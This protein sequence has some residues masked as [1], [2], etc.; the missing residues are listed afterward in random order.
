MNKI[1][2]TMQKLL[3]KNILLAVM[4]F[5]LIMLTRA[6]HELTSLNLP[7]ASLA[8][9]IAAGI[10]L[11]HRKFL[12]LFIALIVSVDAYIININNMTHIN[13]ETSYLG[14]IFTYILTWELGRKFLS[15]DKSLKA[16]L[17]FP[18][19]F[20][21]IVSSYTISFSSHYFLSGWIN[22]P[23]FYDGLSFLVNNFNSFFIPNAVYFGLLYGILKIIHKIPKLS[24]LNFTSN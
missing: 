4:L 7:D 22:N 2:F 8:I 14:H 15:G 9:F 3:T 11:K 5:F 10:F 16:K 20:F 17:F 18:I 6:S 19:A 21:T 24:A 23:N 12:F 1:N 13:F